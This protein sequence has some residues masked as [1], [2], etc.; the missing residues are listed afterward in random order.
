M[1]IHMKA[2]WDFFVQHV[3]P[4]CTEFVLNH[5]FSY[6]EI[7]VISELPFVARLILF[8]VNQKKL[9]GSRLKVFKKIRRKIKGI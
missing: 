2:N 7:I 1:L 5:S 9:K 3:F 6:M 8:L 4:I